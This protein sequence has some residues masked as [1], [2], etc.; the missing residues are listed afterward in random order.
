M[1]KRKMPPEQEAA[2][3]HIQAVKLRRARSILEKIVAAADGYSAFVDTDGTIQEIECGSC[4]EVKELAL[5]GLSVIRDMAIS[6]MIAKE[7]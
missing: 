7:V 5:L 3:L 6:E 1:P 4:E 2:I